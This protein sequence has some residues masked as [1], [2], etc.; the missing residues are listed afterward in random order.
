[1]FA[2]SLLL[3]GARPLCGFRNMVTIVSCVTQ[4]GEVLPSTPSR[5]GVWGTH[6]SLSLFLCVLGMH[7]I[8]MNLYVSVYAVYIYTYVT[9]VR[10]CISK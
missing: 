4:T 7:P 6:L 5:I 8:Y 3:E 2:A 9:S 1:M 10:K